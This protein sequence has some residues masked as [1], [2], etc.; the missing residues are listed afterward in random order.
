MDV[1]GY[2]CTNASIG[3]VL[4]IRPMRVSEA[5]R[6]TRYRLRE[7]SGGDVSMKISLSRNNVFT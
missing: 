4:S 6:L 2:G 5:W 3:T 7:V 1:G